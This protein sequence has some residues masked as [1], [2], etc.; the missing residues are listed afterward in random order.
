MS[1]VELNVDLIMQSTIFILSIALIFVSL[2]IFSYIWANQTYKPDT[3]KIDYPKGPLKTAVRPINVIGKP[4]ASSR[5][6]D[7]QEKEKNNDMFL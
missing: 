6:E 7:I 4:L 3:K 5:R 2:A 1:R